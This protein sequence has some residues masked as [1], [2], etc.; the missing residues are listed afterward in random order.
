M[1]PA[2]FKASDHALANVEDS[3][4]W[5]GLSLYVRARR[6]NQR[7]RTREP[8]RYPN[9]VSLHADHDSVH[10]TVGRTFVSAVEQAAHFR[11]RAIPIG[12]FWAPTYLVLGG[13][14]I[15]ESEHE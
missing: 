7:G 1:A 14:N 5:T 12:S 15:P 11:L 6:S 3:G 13:F 4:V 10:S 2:A 9:H 8:P